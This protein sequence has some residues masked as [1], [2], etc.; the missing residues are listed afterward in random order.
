METNGL[1]TVVNI[2]DYLVDIAIDVIVHRLLTVP[3]VSQAVSRVLKENKAKLVVWL[4][5]IVLIPLMFFGNGKSA[6]GDAS[7]AYENFPTLSLIAEYREPSIEDSMVPNHTPFGERDDMT[8]TA[9]YHD[10]SY[11]HEFGHWHDALDMV[12]SKKYYTS[13]QAYKRTGLPIVFSTLSGKACSY[14]DLTN[15]YTVTVESFDGKFRTLYHH[16]QL[17]FIPL[18][19]CANVIAGT[20]IGIMG[21]T[22]YATGPHVHY[23]VYKKVNGTWFDVDPLGY[24]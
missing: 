18:R 11:Y 8:I 16:Q 6:E 12:P 10:E 24:L 19:T 1:G 14:G 15:G 2:L 17:N 22:G 20:P 5:A 23:S 9:Y 4:L 13:N 3:G 7:L 21:E